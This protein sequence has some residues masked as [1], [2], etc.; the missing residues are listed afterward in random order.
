VQRCEPQVHHLD[1]PFQSIFTAPAQNA[2][3]A[4]LQAVQ[5]AVNGDLELAERVGDSALET[6]ETYVDATE[7]EGSVFDAERVTSSRVFQNELS[8]QR[9]DLSTLAEHRR[10]DRGLVERLRGHSHEA[11]FAAITHHRH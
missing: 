6:F 8:Q 2:V 7:G 3:I 11:G 9:E 5:C 4:V 1:D 10:L